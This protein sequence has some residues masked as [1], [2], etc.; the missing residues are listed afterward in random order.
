MTTPEGYD[1]SAPPTGVSINIGPTGSQ[2]RS[3]DGWPYGR[4]GLLLHLGARGPAG[5]P[6]HPGPR[7]QLTYGRS[8]RTDHASGCCNPTRG[9]TAAPAAAPRANA[10]TRRRGWPPPAGG[11]GLP[12]RQGP[13]WTRPQSGTPLHRDTT[14]HRHHHDHARSLRGHRPLRCGARPQPC[15][16]SPPDPTTSGAAVTRR[17]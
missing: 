17:S 11:G 5:H 15:Q 8:I 9:T 13:L 4:T 16:P 14:P 1:W 10:V 7:R 12:D 6:A 3:H 2:M